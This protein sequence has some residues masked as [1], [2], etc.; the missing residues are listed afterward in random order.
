MIKLSVVTEQQDRIHFINVTDPFSKNIFYTNVGYRS[1]RGNNGEYTNGIKDQLFD[2]IDNE[3]LEAISEY[4]K[5]AA[6]TSTGDYFNESLLTSKYKIGVNASNYELANKIARRA[7]D[8]C[9]VDTGNLRNSVMLQ[10]NG[11][12]GYS[13]IFNCDYAWFVHEFTWRTI[14]RSKNPLA[15]HKWLEIAYQEVLKEEGFI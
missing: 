15:R 12:G 7:I 14:D 5:P 11:R 13:V 2:I 6:I 8:Y 9:P 1:T 10:G 3:L 4:I